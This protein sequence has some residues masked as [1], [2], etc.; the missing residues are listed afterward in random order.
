GEAIVNIKTESSDNFKKIKKEGP[1]ESHKK[2]LNWMLHNTSIANKGYMM[3][4]NEDKPEESE[5][6]SVMYNPME[7]K[8][9][10]DTVKEA[11]SE[12]D[13]MLSTGKISR[14]DLYSEIDKY[15]ILADVS[16]YSDEFREM[17]K[18]ISTMKLT[19]EEEED[20]RAIRDRVSKQREPLRLY[21]YR[22]KYDDTI[23]ERAEVGRQIN[24]ETY[25]LKGS[26][27]AIKLSGV[28]IVKDNPN[29]DK[30]M[31]FLRDNMSDGDNVTIEVA[32]D[33]MKRK[34]KDMLQTTKA[35]VH[36]NGMNIN[37]ELIKRGYADEDEK[38]FSATGV[39]ARFNSIQR[40]F[41]KAWENIAHFDSFANTKL[42]QVR[43]ATEDYERKHVYNKDFKEW[44]DPVK[45][46]L[47]PFVWTNTN[48]TGGVLIGAGVGYMF[49][50]AGSKYGKLL[51]A[52]AGAALVGGSKMYKAGYE[53]K[54]GEKW[55]PEEKRKERE[56]N[57]YMDKLKFLKNRKLFEVYSQK[58]LN[59]DGIDVKTM[60]TQNKEQGKH[61][62]KRVREMEE[63]KKEYKKT[64]D[65]DTGDFED[66]G[67][68][69]KLVDK[70]PSLIRSMITGDGMDNIAESS[71]KL[72]NLNIYDAKEKLSD[73]VGDF[74]DSVGS[75]SKKKE[76]ALMKTVNASIN[77]NKNDRKTFD[78]SENAMKA[79]QYYNE[80]EKTMYGYDP[81]EEL[82]NII[83]ALP[84]KE[85]Q[86]FRHFLEAPKKERERILEIAPSYMKRALQNAYGMEVDK[87]DSLPSY[88][89]EHYLPGDDWDGWQENYDLNAMKV[90]MI[91]TQGL[92]LGSFDM[93]QD[94][95]QKADMYGPTAIPN[96][97]YKT[98]DIQSIKSKMQNILGSAGYSDLDFSF[99]FGQAESNINL[100]MYQDKKDRYEE[101]LNERLGIKI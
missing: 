41:G 91:Q 93:W 19:K 26:D 79:I 32:E 38:D 2:Q 85:R 16:P 35:V 43:S 82:T 65:L 89:S 11:R 15:R 54:T 5:M 25:M 100:Q 22:F 49:G 18:K 63:I 69:F 29:Y 12:V 87:K 28:N 51:G 34:N 46:F 90:K 53:A 74:I 42:L 81:G 84:K 48:R 67:V 71:S 97:E 66:A 13:S 3:Y 73:Y 58:A 61:R 62:K 4:V 88:F 94:D 39:K 59:E 55:I 10:I 44:Q 83:S 96:M 47:K 14:A 17:N 24:A 52:V 64:G 99:T 60:M 37:R 101:K 45:D 92:E 80:S 9:T 57:D 1:K 6:M 77:E 68:K 21:D 50:S 76:K 8:R 23:K 36:S 78:L 7:Y 70:L 30:A 33:T 95:K 72:Y 27:E 98:K 86:Y 40:G 20:V 56:L 75:S 31:K